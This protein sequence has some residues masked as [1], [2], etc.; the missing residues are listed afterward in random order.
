VEKE[1]TNIDR[2]ESGGSGTEGPPENKEIIGSPAT[3]Q[4]RDAPAAL[5]VTKFARHYR[6][7]ASLA[8]QFAVDN[9]HL[10]DT[11]AISQLC[12]A[13]QE[14]L[15]QAK[16]AQALTEIYLALDDNHREAV[17][18]IIIAR[19]KDISTSAHASWRRFCDSVQF[20]RPAHEEIQSAQKKFE[21]QAFQFQE[22]LKKFI[23]LG[24]KLI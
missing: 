12:R 13:T 7:C 4:E 24:D 5:F 6:R 19:F 20:I 3:I 14:M 17:L 2:I 18:P 9:P 15:E 16:A 22:T 10:Q 21:P 8:R 23:A 1:S 11:A